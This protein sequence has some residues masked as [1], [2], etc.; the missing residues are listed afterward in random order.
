MRP[1]AAKRACPGREK[2]GGAYAAVSIKDRGVR[3]SFSG[4]YAYSKAAPKSPDNHRQIC[5]AFMDKHGGH[6][7]SFVIGDADV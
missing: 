6:N 7:S 1:F 5:C 4:H 3:I 2:S